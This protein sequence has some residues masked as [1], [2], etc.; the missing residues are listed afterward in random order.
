MPTRLTMLLGLSALL[1]IVV[2][3]TGTQETAADSLM[4]GHAFTEAEAALKLRELAGTYDSAEGWKQR[5]QKIRQGIL[6]GAQLTRRPEPCPLDPVRHTKREL[7]GYSVENVAFQSLPGYWVTGNLYLP[8]EPSESM[9]GVLCPHGHAPDKRLKEDVQARCAALARMGAA[10]YAYDMV[11]FGE[12]DPCPHDATGV[13]RLQ[14]YNSTRA[15]DFLLSLP[16]VDPDRLAVTGASGGGTQSFL[17]AA[18]DERIDVSVPVVQ[19]SAHFYGGCGCESGMPI[20]MRP[21]HETNNVEIAA[22]FAPKPQL[23]ISDGEDWTKNTPRVE[24]P[25]IKNVYALLDAED[26]VENAHFP[27]EGHDYGPSKRRAAYKF[28]AKHLDLNLE[29]IQDDQREI[30]EAFVTVFPMDELYVFDESHPRPD[31][32]L[33]DCADVM[34]QLD[35]E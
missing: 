16:G 21:G 1:L 14:T 30:T 20:H 34:K 25:Y 8:A 35:A 13:L 17:L 27:D 12:N 10:V 5:S 33:E 4:Q 26:Q 29:A 15:V 31:G 28:L 18:I 3:T 2:E 6:E 9:P 7:D 11:G 19:V 24:F 22:S 23:I 32:A